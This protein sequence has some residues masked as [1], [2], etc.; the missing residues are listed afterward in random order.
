MSS[1]VA[2]SALKR[3]PKPFLDALSERLLDNTYGAD[4]LRVAAALTS[5]SLTVVSRGLKHE[6][7]KVVHTPVGRERAGSLDLVTSNKKL[8]PSELLREGGDFTLVIMNPPFTRSDRISQLI[9][10]EAKRN[11]TDANLTFGKVE[12][13]NIFTAGLSKPF[14][15]LADRLLQE[16]AG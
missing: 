16:G 12:L 3:E 14:L 2:A 5:A 9:G 8:I 7:L 1:T 4:A 11:I 15:A 6:R 10:D 13:K